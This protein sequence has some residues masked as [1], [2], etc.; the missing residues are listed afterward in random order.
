M[1]K[2]MSRLSSGTGVFFGFGCGCF[3]GGGGFGSHGC[4]PPAASGG[5]GAH[6]QRGRVRSFFREALV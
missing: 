6:F 2:E 1:R 5:T 3:T 4:F